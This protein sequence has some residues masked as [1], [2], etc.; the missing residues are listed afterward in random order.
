VLFFTDGLIEE[1]Q[2]GGPEF[3]ETRLRDLIEIVGHDAGPV[4]EMVRR[5][6]RALMQ[7][8]GGVTSDDATLLLVEWRGATADHLALVEQAQPSA[9]G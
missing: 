2:D 5:L 7:E 9:P 8:R 6:S 4:Q 1:H 3:G